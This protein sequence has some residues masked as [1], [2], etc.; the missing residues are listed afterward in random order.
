MPESICVKSNC[1]K[2]RWIG[3]LANLLLILNLAKRLHVILW[4]T[5]MFQKGI[6]WVH[7]ISE[8]S[9][10]RNLKKEKDGRIT[11]ES[12]CRDL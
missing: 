5:G 10:K 11:R 7:C 2:V 1:G 9:F 8:L 3:M 4:A 12:N 6:Q